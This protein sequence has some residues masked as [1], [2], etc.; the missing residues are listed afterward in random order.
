MPADGQN[1]ASAGSAAIGN[2]VS[3]AGQP[4]NN[5]QQAQQQAKGA[6]QFRALAESNGF[7]VTQEGFDALI[8]PIHNGQDMMLQVRQ[9]VQVIKRGMKLGDAPVAKAVMDADHKVAAGDPSS[10]DAVMTLYTQT[11]DDIEAGLKQALKNYQTGEDNNEHALKQVLQ[12][13]RTEN[14]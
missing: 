1:L 3:A 12:N 7:G 14:V 10:L 13:D 4:P 8:K 11:L 9:H 5:V 2:A 6:K